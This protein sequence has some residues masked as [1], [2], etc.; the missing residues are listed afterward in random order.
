LA[1]YQSNNRRTGEYLAIVVPDVWTVAC[2][3]KMEISET[4]V[5]VIIAERRL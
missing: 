2:I 4:K 3:Q 5:D 1:I